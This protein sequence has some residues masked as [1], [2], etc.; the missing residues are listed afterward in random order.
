MCISGVPV[1]NLLDWMT[2]RCL[3]HRECITWAKMLDQLE[4]HSSHML[5]Y[6]AIIFTCAI[7]KSPYPGRWTSLLT[8]RLFP[9]TKPYTFRVPLGTSVSSLF[10][11]YVVLSAKMWGRMSRKWITLWCWLDINL[12]ATSA[13]CKETF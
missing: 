6:K 13:S 11:S 12:N 1:W 4:L 3:S 2:S 8:Q 7:W 10:S 9:L 5:F